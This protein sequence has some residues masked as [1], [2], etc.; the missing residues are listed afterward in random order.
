MADTDTLGKVKV[1]LARAAMAGVLKLAVAAA[2]Q[3]RS[4]PCRWEGMSAPNVVVMASAL[5]AKGQD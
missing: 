1:G 4:S 5:T 2:G 3:E